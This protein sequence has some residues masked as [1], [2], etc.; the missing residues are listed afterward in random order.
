MTTQTGPTE[1]PVL[2]GTSLLAGVA[3]WP[4]AHSLSPRL[5]GYWLN[6]HGINGA[7]VPLAVKPEGFEAAIRG[8][9]AAG[10][11]GLNVT[12][13]HKEAAFALSDVRDAAAKRMGAVNTLVF[14]ESGAIHG[15]NTDG[16]G[17]MENVRQGAPGWQTEKP[18]V[19]F[20]AGGAARGVAF[21]LIDAGCRDI[22]IVNRTR[23]RAESLAKDAASH[24]VTVSAYDSNASASALEGT[25]LIVNT[26][27]LGM[28]GHPPLELDLSSAP[29][30]AV[31]TDIV[32]AP[33]DTPLLVQA[34]AR[35][36]ITVDGLGM[37]LHQAR[38]GFA[39]WFGVEPEVDDALRA[40]VLAGR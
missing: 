39:A 33:L 29:L 9:A 23:E 6:C 11:R 31:V 17:F 37:L 15:S 18:A 14:A 27:T 25:G 21:A 22:R 13:P 5:H 32:Y 19:L 28:S 8:L 26:T 7:Y 36:H 2:S 38:P 1:S 20:G 40:F 3:G 30:D 35:G 10:F 24:G 4:V 16:L 34:R 12:V